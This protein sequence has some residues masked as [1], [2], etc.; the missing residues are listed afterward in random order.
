[1]S[2]VLSGDTA[3][4]DAVIR[5]F[6]KKNI[7]VVPAFAGGLDGRPAIDGFF[8]QN[9]ISN[10]DAMVSLSGFSLVGGPAYNNTDAA[11]ETL[12]NLDIPYIAAHPLEFQTLSQWSNSRGGLGP[13]EMDPQKRRLPFDLLLD[14]SER[15]APPYRWLMVHHREQPEYCFSQTLG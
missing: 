12:K 10:I 3:H 11:V 15:S 7:Q 2:Y 13:I 14:Y 4:Y 1:R 8:V 5:E 9:G 6:E